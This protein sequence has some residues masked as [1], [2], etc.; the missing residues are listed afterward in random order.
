MKDGLGDAHG[1]PWE[2]HVRHEEVASTSVSHRN[3]L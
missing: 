2:V 1:N 3:S